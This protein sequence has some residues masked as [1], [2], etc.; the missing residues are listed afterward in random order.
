MTFLQKHSYDIGAAFAGLL[1]PFFPKRQRI[2]VDNILKCGITSDAAKARQIAKK[3]WCHLA[4]HIA[5]ALFVPSVV[6]KD[7][8]RE[9]LEFDEAAPE[10]VKL[11]LDTP[12]TPILL[13]SGHHGVWEAATNT[14]SFARPMI[15]IA[16]VMNNRF[17]ARWMKK[18]HFR[19]NITIINKNNGFSSAA[20]QQWVKERAAMTILMDQ[21][22]SSGEMLQFLGRR[23]KTFTTATRLA[24]R[25]GYPIVVGSFVRVAPFR[26]R[27]VG[28]TP[29]VFSKDADRAAATQLLNDRLGE[30]IKAYPEQY[31][32]I[33][34]RWRYD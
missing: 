10:T 29:V 27:L 4:G 23:A 3:S 12:D 34:R 32:W 5:E 11:L 30:A 18:H 25:T 1:W 16:R 2:A 9:H 22:T 26:Y 8:W 20:L 28:G 19:G 7:N 21:H 17:V 13:V 14:L 6:N 31:L 33:H 15:A 24:I